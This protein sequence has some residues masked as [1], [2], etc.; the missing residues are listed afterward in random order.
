MSISLLVNLNLLL[1][2]KDKYMQKCLTSIIAFFLSIRSS[3]G[4]FLIS[5][6][7]SIS[8]VVP[9]ISDLFLS[10]TWQIFKRFDLDFLRSTLQLI[11]QNTI[12]K[13]SVLICMRQKERKIIFRFQITQGI[14][15]VLLISNYM[16]MT[17]FLF[18]SLK[19]LSGNKFLKYTLLDLHS[20]FQKALHMILWEKTHTLNQRLINL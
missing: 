8:E 18:F 11:N 3:F 6:L 15:S 17:H 14:F 10:Y 9:I 1:L 12:I 13:K 20:Y 2:V 4:L 7:N 16:C 19:L 5:Q